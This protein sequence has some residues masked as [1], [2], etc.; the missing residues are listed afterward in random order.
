MSF[1][2]WPAPPSPGRSDRVRG[3]VT[4]SRQG[5]GAPLREWIAWL[6]GLAAVLG[7]YAASWGLL[8]Q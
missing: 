2:D 7:L 1:I 6:L 5:Q 4:R 3:R 8:L